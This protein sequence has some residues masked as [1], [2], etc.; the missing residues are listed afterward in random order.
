MIG[1]EFNDFKVPNDYSDH[2]LG[3]FKINSVAIFETL[4]LFSLIFG[5]FESIYSN[6]PLQFTI[7]STMNDTTK[8]IRQDYSND[9]SIHTIQCNCNTVIDLDH[10]EA[11]IY[12]YNLEKHLCS[13]VSELD[14]NFIQ[15]LDQTFNSKKENINAHKYVIRVLEL[16]RRYFGLNTYDTLFDA[17]KSDTENLNTFRGFRFYF[18]TKFRLNNIQQLEKYTRM[19]KMKR[20]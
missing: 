19:I 20:T 16:Y 6:Y 2:L 4:E 12:R 10:L 9:Y 8:E 17:I 7:I 1:K 11:N 5:T 3:I 18:S 15:I 13:Y 14:Q